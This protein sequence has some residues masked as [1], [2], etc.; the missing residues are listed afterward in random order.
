MKPRIPGEPFLPVL[1]LTED[2][3][4]MSM[5]VRK[6]LDDDFEVVLAKDGDEAL[7]IL[8]SRQI[9]ML[10]LD[11]MMPKFNGF[12]VCQAARSD[13]RYRDIPIV[14]VTAK[15]APKEQAFAIKM[16][17][18]AVIAKPFHPPELRETCRKI[19]A[20]KTGKK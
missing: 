3:P 7:K 1:L 13:P 16:G 12:Q 15:S 8:Q 2:D 11:V 6:M 5:T 9:D 14:F 20:E 10:V 19:F 18:D 4:D 17:G